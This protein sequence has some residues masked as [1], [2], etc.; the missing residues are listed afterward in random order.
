MHT[1]IF[2]I[3]TFLAKC[4]KIFKKCE[5]AAVRQFIQ[6]AYGLK[7]LIFVF[8]SLVPVEGR[9]LPACLCVCSFVCHVKE[10]KLMNQ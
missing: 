3:D 8:L 2:Y 9:G 7:I 4:L 10:K 6:P 5:K 1:L